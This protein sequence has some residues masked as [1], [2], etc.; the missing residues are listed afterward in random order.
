LDR[1]KHG[2]SMLTRSRG[3]GAFVLLVVGL[4]ASYVA[5]A[6]VGLGSL[7]GSW[8][9]RLPGSVADRLGAARILHSQPARTAPGSG[10]SGPGQAGNG[11]PGAGNGSSGNQY[12]GAPALTP[13]APVLL[14]RTRVAHHHRRRQTAR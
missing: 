1:G 6:A 11:L 13:V 2:V 5:L 7:G 12:P 14:P 10:G 4:S 3:V 8:V 9:L